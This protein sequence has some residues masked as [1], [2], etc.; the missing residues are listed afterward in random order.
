M[1]VRWH[2]QSRLIVNTE[3]F[4]GAVAK[5]LALGGESLRMGNGLEVLLIR[6]YLIGLHI[7]PLSVLPSPYHFQNTT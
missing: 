7:L 6:Q 4:C 3:R 5:F 2:A 1:Q